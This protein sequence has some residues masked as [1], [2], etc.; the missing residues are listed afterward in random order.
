MNNPELSFKLDS[1]YI[2]RSYYLNLQKRESESPRISPLKCYQ[3]I[4]NIHRRTES[5]KVIDASE[6]ESPARKS[7]YIPLNEG[8]KLMSNTTSSS[9][10]SRISGRWTDRSRRVDPHL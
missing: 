1:E 3:T 7:L 6:A 8:S 2:R 10:L 4:T 5:A 9:N